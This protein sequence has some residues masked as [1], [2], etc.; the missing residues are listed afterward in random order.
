MYS[1]DIP[2][3]LCHSNAAKQT[4]P[5]T[6]FENL[7]SLI[8]GHT[9]AGLLESELTQ[10]GLSREGFTP[11]ISHPPWTDRGLLSW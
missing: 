4:S 5:K 2:A 8:A 1:G 11:G 10:V 3:A 6:L 7:M 9:H